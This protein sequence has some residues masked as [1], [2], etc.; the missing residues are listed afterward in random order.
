MRARVYEYHIAEI[1]LPLAP[2]ERYVGV[3]ERDGACVC[4]RVLALATNRHL[5]GVTWVLMKEKE[6]G[7]ACIY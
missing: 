4:E 6:Q 2:F 5:K 1:I 7:I 3:S